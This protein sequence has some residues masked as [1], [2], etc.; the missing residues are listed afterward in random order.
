MRIEDFK[1]V[2]DSTSDEDIEE[3]L[4]KRYGEGVNEFWLSHAGARFPAMSILAKGDIAALHYFP[5]E[6]DAGM[7]SIG[8]KLNLEAG[9][10]TMFYIN[11]T[12]EEQEIPNGM[13]VPFSLALKAAKEFSVNKEPPACIEWFVL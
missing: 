9:G 13:I 10:T 12:E 1:G 6:Q 2:N 4:A 7:T 8:G 3:A 11:T 5:K